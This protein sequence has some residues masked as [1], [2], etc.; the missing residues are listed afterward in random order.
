MRAR[1]PW[2]DTGTKMGKR[3]VRP[4]VDDDEW[5]EAERF[6]ALKRRATAKDFRSRAF[7]DE[8][9]R[10][11]VGKSLRVLRRLLA[12]MGDALDSASAFTSDYSQ[13]WAWSSVPMHISFSK[14]EN[15]LREERATIA[16]HNSTRAVLAKLIAQKEKADKTNKKRFV[17]FVAKG[18]I[19][20]K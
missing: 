18:S 14:T 4:G 19:N 3:T 20:S 7:K 11:H 5:R 8:V 12:L 15:E 10:R 16:C 6:G 2:C 9:R 17:P 1:R 13:Q